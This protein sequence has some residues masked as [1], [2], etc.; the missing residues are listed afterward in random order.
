MCKAKKYKRIPNP[1][2]D[3]CM[4][5]EIEALFYNPYFKIVA[6]CCGHS[7]YER[8]IIVQNKNLIWDLVSG[9][10]IPRKRNFYKRD[11]QGLYFIP[12]VHKNIKFRYLKD[13]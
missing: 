12:E 7:V 4:V 10:H 6:C 11:R 5:N 9:Q 8:T 13:K 3:K 2:I 1:K